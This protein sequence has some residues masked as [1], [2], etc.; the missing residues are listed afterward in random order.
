MRKLYHNHR[1]KSLEINHHKSSK[2]KKSIKWLEVKR[3]NIT[4]KV[5]P[6]NQRLR[7]YDKQG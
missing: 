7:K 1:S 6:K 3:E 5:K 4:K 2:I